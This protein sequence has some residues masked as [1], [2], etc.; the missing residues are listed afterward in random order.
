MHGL[1]TSSNLRWWDPAA[2][3]RHPFLMSVS[4]KQ[5]PVICL[6]FSLADFCSSYCAI[7]WFFAKISLFSRPDWILI[8]K[9]DNWWKKWLS[10]EMSP[11]DF[12]LRCMNTVFH[13]LC[14]IPLL[15]YVQLTA[16]S[17]QRRVEIKCSPINLWTYFSHL[18]PHSYKLAFFTPRKQASPNTFERLKN[19]DAW[20][21][22]FHQHV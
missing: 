9:T 15:I 11:A 12:S 20:L 3:N 21:S 19:T 16:K 10:C 17:L 14:D 4:K 6:I 2:W 7:S 5:R 13:F 1:V 8:Q 18:H 22:T